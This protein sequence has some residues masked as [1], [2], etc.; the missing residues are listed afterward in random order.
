[1]K[2]YIDLF[3]IFNFIIDFIITL[4]VSI[5]LKRKSNYIR[6]ILSSLLGGVSS[7]LLFTSLNKILIEIISIIL[8]VVISFGYKGIRYVIKNILYMYILST[9]LGGIIYLFNIKVSNNVFLSYL[10]IIIIA[11]EVMV[12]YI[13]EN[14][15]MKN[16]YNNYYKVD[17]YFKSNDKLSL[18]GFVDTGNNLYDPYKKR[19]IILISNKYYRNDNFILVPY[20]T[21]SGNGL[22][23]CIK[24]DIIFIEGIGY[25]GNVLVGFSDS[26]NLIDGIDVILHKDVMKG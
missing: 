13:K 25:K 22:L 24:P 7:L 4:S 12:L 20:H 10:I 17:I 16:I 6:M 1:M 11:I 8:M 5:I 14:K 9:L 23:K 18:I 3:F 21:L 26:P 15:K 2:M 19:P